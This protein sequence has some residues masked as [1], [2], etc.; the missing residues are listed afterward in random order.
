MKIK[1]SHPV[2]AKKNDKFICFL[3]L[4]DDENDSTQKN[5]KENGEVDGGG[6]ERGKNTFGVLEN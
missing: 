6:R 5:T 3:S 1:I 2:S 4:K